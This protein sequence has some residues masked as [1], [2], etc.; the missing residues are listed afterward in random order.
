MK[1]FKEFAAEDAM[2][3]A[4]AGIPQDTANMGPRKRKRYPITRRFIEVMGR[5]RKIQK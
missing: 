3:T 2:T 1:K 5:M 4:A